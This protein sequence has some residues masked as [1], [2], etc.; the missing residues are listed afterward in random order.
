MDN[1]VHR[2][3]R[4]LWLLL[5]Y[6]MSGV[7]FVERDVILER[8]GLALANSGGTNEETNQGQGKEL[9]RAKSALHEIR[10]YTVRRGVN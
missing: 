4:V 10:F 2:G 5:C 9:H 1:D 3:A 6:R 8:I 7:P